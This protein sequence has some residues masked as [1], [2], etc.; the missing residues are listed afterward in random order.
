MD[1][2][3]MITLIMKHIKMWLQLT[4]EI[5]LDHLHPAADAQ[6]RSLRA[7]KSVDQRQFP[8]IHRRII[9]TR[10]CADMPIMITWPCVITA[11]QKQTVA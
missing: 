1:A 5:K 10:K 2:M 11:W 3:D 4:F 9:V 8:K 6:D 7:D